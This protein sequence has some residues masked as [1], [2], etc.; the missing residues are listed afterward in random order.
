M[1]KKKTCNQK[2]WIFKFWGLLIFEN[3]VKLIDFYKII[4]P[5]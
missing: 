3:T 1:E 4:Q 5:L 2:N